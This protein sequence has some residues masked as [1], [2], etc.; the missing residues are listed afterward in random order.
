MAY[1]LSLWGAERIIGVQ[2]LDK[3]YDIC[4]QLQTCIF[5]TKQN[6][7]FKRL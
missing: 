3:K 6:C 4:L 7:T 1:F 5:T 2:A